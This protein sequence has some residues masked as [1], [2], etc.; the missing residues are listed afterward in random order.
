MRGTKLFW[1]IQENFYTPANLFTLE[2]VLQNFNIPYDIVNSNTV[3]KYTVGDLNIVACGGNS[4]NKLSNK[5]NWKSKDFY[6]EFDFK[7]MLEKYG[8]YLLNSDG[9][10]TNTEDITSFEGRKFI[11]PTKDNKVFNGGIFTRDEFQDIVDRVN[12]TEIMVSN[13][14]DIMEEV[15]FF[16]INGEIISQSRYRLRGM[17]SISQYVS[18]EAVDFVKRVL[19]IWKPTNGFV[20]DV[21]LTSG[22]YKIIEF[23][24]LLSSSF[25]AADVDKIVAKIQDY[26]KGESL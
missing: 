22:G 9:V 5:L 10:I 23:N 19:G 11:R 21:A 6:S 20:I 8:D 26:F 2:T 3:T 15:R 14:K 13:T 24:N 18:K 4:I 7:T 1:L 16:I 17:A 25:Y 12:K